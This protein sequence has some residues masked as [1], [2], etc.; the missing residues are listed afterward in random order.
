MLLLRPNTTICKCSPFFPITSD[1]RA[2]AVFMFGRERERGDLLLR[3]ACGPVEMPQYA[4]SYW[5]VQRAGIACWLERRTRDRKV[6]SSNLRQARRDN[7]LLHSQL[8]VLTLIRCPFYSRV[9]AA[10][11]KRSRSFCQKCRWLVTLKHTYA[12]DPTKSEWADYAAVQ[13]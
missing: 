7:F 6:A 8:C 5:H 13:A 10:A 2:V 11:R 3:L 12:F 1:K 4:S 9:T